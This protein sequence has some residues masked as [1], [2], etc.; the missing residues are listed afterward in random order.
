MKKKIHAI[1]LARGGSKGLKRK[2]LFPINKKP[3][4]YWSINCCLKSKKIDKIW[5]SSDNKKI[6]KLAKKYG[7]KTIIRPKFLSSDNASSDSAWL[8]AVKY[9]EKKNH[10][11][12]VIGLQPT[13]PIRETKDIDKSI[14]KF[15]KFKYDSLFSSS[16]KD[17]A[18]TWLVGN[19]KKITPNYNFKKRPRRQDLKKEIKENGSI[20]IFNKKKFLIFKNRL[21]GKIGNYLMEK[22]KSFEI[23]DIHDALLV[24]TIMKNLNNFKKIKN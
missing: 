12:T 20:Y 17:T 19:N 23:D 13:S 18:F 11:D 14:K 6:L 24:D 7:A 10:I 2:N 8:H 3:L 22:N 4:I 16:N 21:F 1:I 15:F 5:V 9:I